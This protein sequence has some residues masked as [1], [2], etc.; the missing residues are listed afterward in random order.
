MSMLEAGLRGGA[1]AILLLVAILFLRDSGRSPVGRNCALC[2]LSA[3]GYV[4]CSVPGVAKLDTPFGFSLLV[5]SLGLPALFWMSAAAVFD[6]EFKPSWR[7]GFAWLGL[8]VLG[9]WSILDSHPLVDFAYY[10]LCLLFV[11]L[12]A[13]HALAGRETDLVEARRRLRMLLAVS[14]ACYA[15]AII[16]ADLV[17]PG[18]STSAPFSIVNAVALAAM[19]FAVAISWLGVACETPSVSP[20][21]SQRPLLRTEAG[22]D[23]AHAARPF[24]KQEI[25]LLAAL[26]ELMEKQKLYRHDGLTIAVLA[27]RLGIPEYRLRRLINRRLGHR[28]FSSFVSGYRLAEARAALA[29]PVQADV[30]ILTIAL[31]TGFQSLAPFNRAFKMTAGMTPSEYRRQCLSRPNPAACHLTSPRFRNR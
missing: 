4:M 15:A 23:R 7:R 18:S 27:A 17:S 5:V 25:A 9:L 22:A 30:P 24:D 2:L 26:R 20:A 16:V 8:V 14:T 12:A 13:W 31:D 29:D 19:T 6:D 21:N 1:M 11:G 28:N 3:A 10:A